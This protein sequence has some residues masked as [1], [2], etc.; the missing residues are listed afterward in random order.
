MKMIALLFALSVG[1]SA[2]AQSQSPK[3]LDQI[4]SGVGDLTLRPDEVIRLSDEGW[5]GSGEAALRLS[6][7]YGSVRLDFDRAEYWTIIAAENGNAV[8][9]YNAWVQL[10]DDRSS[11]ADDKKR[12]V[13]WL[14]KSAAQNDPDAIRELKKL[15]PE[16]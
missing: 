5:N 4:I 14:R 12:A 7:Y 11:S 15:K 16:G 2:F 3:S 9:Q 1:F 10:S 8:A 6:L 13:F